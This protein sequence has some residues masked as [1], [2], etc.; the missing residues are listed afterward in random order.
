MA[1]RDGLGAHPGG[2]VSPP[3][4][5]DRPSLPSAPAASGHRETPAREVLPDGRQ[6][7]HCG[8]LTY[9]TGGLMLLFCWLLWGDFAWSM[10]ERSVAPMVQL[11]FKQLGATDTVAALF[12]AS[13]PAVIGLFLGPVISYRSDRHRGPRGRRIP[14]LMITTPLVALSIFGMAVGPWL[15]GNVHAWLGVRSP[16]E[17][18]L[19][20]VFL[21]LFWTI[22]EFAVIAAGAVFGGLI[23]DVVPRPVLGRFFGLF[24]ALSLIAGII[25]NYWILGHAETRY[26]AIFCGV[27]LLYGAGLLLMCVKVREGDYP[28]PPP[29]DPVRGRGFTGAARTY[30]RESFTNP[31]YWFVFGAFTVANLCFVPINLYS[32]Y[33]AKSLDMTMQQYGEYIAFTY[34]ISLALAYPLGALVDRFHPLQIGLVVLVGYIGVTLWGGI[35]ANDPSSFGIALVAHGVVSGTYFTTTASLG[36]RLYPR[37][38]FAQFASAGGIL[39][40]LAGAAVPPLIGLYLDLSGHHYRHT[41]LMSFALTVVALGLMLMVYR[42][43]QVLGGVAGY[44]APE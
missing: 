20:V 23:N 37:S 8:T 1:R 13:L 27:G 15:G 21:G 14:Y 7:W 43:F 22:F 30:L 18:V 10:R 6:L 36:Q 25:F 31:Y 35:F 38:R 42:R 29:P 28:P 17:G 32:V 44:R 4:M 34:V 16:G 26:V 41:F 39:G 24:R 40:A 2:P 9:T 3:P 19:A 33:F 11:L 5:S 12:L